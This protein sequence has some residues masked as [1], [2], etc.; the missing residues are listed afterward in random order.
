MVLG[1]PMINSNSGPSQVEQNPNK[2]RI[3]K[4]PITKP[5]HTPQVTWADI[6]RKESIH[7]ND[8]ANVRP[9]DSHGLRGLSQ[10]YA[11]HLAGLAG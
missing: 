4:I 10:R 11:T 2:T 1:S 8:T 6:S 3:N 7:K 9:Q 5:N